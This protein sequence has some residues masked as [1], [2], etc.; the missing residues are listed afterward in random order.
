MI[1]MYR[2]SM[3]G[4]HNESMNNYV[5]LFNECVVCSHIVMKPKDTEDFQCDGYFINTSTGQKIGY[6]WEY[7]DKYF[8]NGR[9][10][11]KKLGQY[12]R[13]IQHEDIEICLQSDSTQTAVAV[14]WHDDFRNETVL[15]R[16]LSTD[17]QRKQNGNTRETSKFWI[18]MNTDVG[19]LKEIL[20]KAFRTGGRSYD[21]T[22]D[23]DE[24]I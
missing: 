13:K 20:E 11:F 19:H 24:P 2:P 23:I 12:E 5:K 7:R 17:Y 10:A 22:Y 6:D 4:I 3:Y 9:F 15:D 21:T 1:Y 18:I 16:E 8:S 14:A